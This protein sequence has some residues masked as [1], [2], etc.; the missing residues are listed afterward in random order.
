MAMNRI[1]HYQHHLEQMDDFS[2]TG[3]V[4]QV[5]GLILESQGPNASFGDLCFVHS[6]A[7]RPILAE[8]VGFREKRILL[9]PLADLAGIGPGSYVIAT[10]RPLK[11]PVGPRLLG[12]V[13]DGLGRPLDN[14]GPVVSSGSYPVAGE[15]VQPLHRQRITQPLP[16]GVRAIDAVLTCGKGQR[17]GIFAGSGVGKSTLLGMMARN[18]TADINVIALI[19]E[20]GR[21]V[22][23]FLERDLGPEGI[24][25]SVVIVATSDQPA[26]VRLKGAM[27]ATAIAE[28]YRDQGA[29]VLFMMDSVTRFANAQR[30]I[31]LAAGEPPAT[32]GFTPSVFALLP[33][34][35][36]RTGPGRE[37]TITGFYTVLVDGDDMNEPIADAVRGILDGHI[38]LS[39]KIAERQQYPAIDIL[40]S[41]SRVM[42]DIASKDHQ[43]RAAKLRSLMAIYRDNEDLISIGAYNNGSSAKIDEAIEHIEGINQFLRQDTSERPTWDSMIQQLSQLIP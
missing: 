24:A 9:M 10:G 5:I 30:E 23:E 34:L 2:Q 11:T 29:D 15:A 27:V 8:V 14:K 18:T 20:R 3:R 42:P 36:E 35:L 7:G 39:R 43:Q 37:G 17:L 28:Y 31:G 6:K 1:Y 40:A 32:R 19:G 38:V 26:M 25:R 21:E 13:L 12:R 41:V 4:T 22:R 33:K 16:V